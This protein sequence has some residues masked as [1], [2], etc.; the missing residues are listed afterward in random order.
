MVSFEGA[1]VSGL[2]VVTVML[3]FEFAVSRYEAVLLTISEDAPKRE[4]SAVTTRRRRCCLIPKAKDPIAHFN[5]PRLPQL[6]KL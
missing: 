4:Q 5:L 6:F 1:L 3:S 2:L